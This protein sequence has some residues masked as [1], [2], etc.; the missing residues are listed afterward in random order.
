MKLYLLYVKLC[1]ISLALGLATYLSAASFA[2]TTFKEYCEIKKC[3][4]GN[5]G[6]GVGS[7]SFNARDSNFSSSVGYLYAGGGFVHNQRIKFDV[8]VRLGGGRNTLQGS[9]FPTSFATSFNA[10]FMDFTAKLGRN[11]LSKQIPLFINL[12]LGLT[13]NTPHKK[14]FGYVQALLGV[15]IDGQVA[16][17]PNLLLSYGVGYGWLS[18]GYTYANPAVFGYYKNNEIAESRSLGNFEFTTNV[19]INYKFENDYVVFIRAVGRYQH[20]NASETIIY[21]NVPLRYPTSNNYAGMLE[22]GVE[23]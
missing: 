4:Y 16:I 23:F 1:L 15:E 21:D 22:M 5:I 3:H 2:S 10:T 17:A 14:N 20:I 12:V 6:L 11:V 7:Y 19:G 18:M 8:D 9:N 13:F